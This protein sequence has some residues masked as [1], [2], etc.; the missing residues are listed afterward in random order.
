MRIHIWPA[1]VC[2]WVLAAMAGQTALAQ[3]PA[4][5]LSGAV[6]QA[7]AIDESDA[8]DD[9]SEAGGMPGWGNPYLPVQYDPNAYGGYGPGVAPSRPGAYC[10]GHPPPTTPP[11]TSP[12]TPP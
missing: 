2:G 11:P 3:R 6:S 7:D 8:D 12:L 10:R 1:L 9:A 4:D 5:E